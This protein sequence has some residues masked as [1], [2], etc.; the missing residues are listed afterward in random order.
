MQFPPNPA[1]KMQLGHGQG[2]A[3][4]DDTGCPESAGKLVVNGASGSEHPLPQSTPTCVPPSSHGGSTGRALEGMIALQRSKWPVGKAGQRRRKAP[5]ACAGVRRWPRPRPFPGRTRPHSSELLG[6]SH[7]HQP[8]IAPVAMC[9]PRAKSTSPG[10]S[11]RRD[12]RSAPCVNMWSSSPVR[13]HAGEVVCCRRG[14]TKR[15]GGTHV[16][17]P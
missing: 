6:T 14:S 5:S 16:F 17:R 2:R 9:N 7:N 3:G 1:S 8:C 10:T 12:S 13:R 4:E 15:H 11:S